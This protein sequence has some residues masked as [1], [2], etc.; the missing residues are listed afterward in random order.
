MGRLVAGSS[1]RATIWIGKWISQKVTF[2][3]FFFFLFF[4]ILSI[5]FYKYLMLYYG[6][7]DIVFYIFCVANI[8]FSEIKLELSGSQ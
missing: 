3:L 6:I 2:L 4:C 5:K 7:L 1:D 8:Y